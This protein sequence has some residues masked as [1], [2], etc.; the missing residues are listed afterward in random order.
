MRQTIIPWAWALCGAFALAPLARAEPDDPAARLR[1]FVDAPAR[2]VWIQQVEGP[3]DDP[4]CWGDQLIIM[5]LDTEDGRGKR[6]IVDEVAH[7]HRPLLSPDG[8]HVVF[9]SLQTREAFVVDWDGGAPRRIGEGYAATVWK[10]PATDL[11]WVYLADIGEEGWDRH[12]A[13]ALYR[14]RIDDPSVRE[15]A[16][17]RA[18]FTIDNV[19]FSADGTRFCSQFTHPRAG[20]A[21]VPNQSWTFLARGCW[22]SMAP[23]NSYLVWIF[24]GPHRNIT[25]H[26]PVEETAWRVPINTAPGMDGFEVYHPRWSNHRSFFTITGPYKVGRPGDNLIPAGGPEVDVLIGRFSED[27]RS[28][29][30]WAQITDNAF[31]NFYPDLWIAYDRAPEAARVPVDRPVD[32]DARFPPGLQVLW[33]DA[34]AANDAGGQRWEAHSYGRAFWGPFA[35]MELDGGWFEI[36]GSGDPRGEYTGIRDAFTLEVVVTPRFADPPHSTPIIAHADAD[37][38]V[39]A[40]EQV[41]NRI[42]MRFSRSGESGDW[43][44]L[45]GEVE[46]QRPTHMVLA[47]DRGALAA[48]RDGEPL[49]RWTMK[50]GPRAWAPDSLHIGRNK[51]DDTAP[52][53]KGRV[54]GLALYDRGLTDEEIAARHARVQN[55]LL[56][57]IEPPEYEVVARLDKVLP[58][59]DPATILPY[60]RAL[61][62]QVYTVESAPAE[63]ALNTGD[64]IAIAHWAILDER[65]EPREFESGERY[66]LRITPFE[67]R[68]LL[69]SER[70]FLDTDF[71]LL[72]LY[73]EAMEARPA[74]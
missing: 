2:L 5:G 52:A 64:S 48:W 1:A 31:G 14:V 56:G 74:G 33:K 7:Y 15:L 68:P 25:I 54:E 69:E 22:T 24:D 12:H 26:D 50:P 55:R 32:P 47:Y 16:W 42:H 63:S 67:D 11:T 40:L 46:P 57:R 41:R 39:W 27:L 4:F 59:A 3:G 71:I 23:D 18:P 8:Q 49:S 73:Y 72:P 19:Q 20:Y 43:V 9:S 66:R 61:L 65:I 35:E 21:D 60:R 30:D 44:A 17:D 51:T 62:A 10:D 29:S 58:P 53:W 37:G 13:R 6:A 36:T 28:V 34:N 70:L 45:L 38:T